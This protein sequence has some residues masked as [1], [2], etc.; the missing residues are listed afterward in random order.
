MHGPPLNQIMQNM[1]IVTLCGEGTLSVF[2]NLMPHY[3]EGLL[4]TVMNSLSHLT[5]KSN[6]LVL[7]SPTGILPSDVWLQRFRPRPEFSQGVCKS[8]RV[9]SGRYDA[10]AFL[11]VCEGAFA[12]RTRAV[13]AM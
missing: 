11:L 13:T 4:I 2:L 5:D 3:E 12:T 10:A 7:F 9:K 8:L 6:C 1:K